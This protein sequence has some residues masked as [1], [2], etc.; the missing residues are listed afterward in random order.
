M[1]R[2]A[3]FTR[4]RILDAAGALAAEGGAAS[5]TIASI[6]ARLGG[7]VGS[8]YHRFASRDLLLSALWLRT[9]ERFQEGLLAALAADDLERAALHTPRWCRENPVDAT[10]LVLHRPEDLVPRWPDELAGARA[11]VNTRL[12][13]ALRAFVERN[14]GIDDT[15]VLFAVV[16][17]PYGAVRR[18]LL[19]RETIPTRL[20]ELIITTCRA[21]T[22]T[23]QIR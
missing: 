20:D 11:E 17:V 3:K 6:A 23:Q 16:D 15:S 1:G 14:R 18:H 7:P 2:P 12:I 8:V 5:I 9:V 10:L 4:D 13:D 19:G 21:V 22:G